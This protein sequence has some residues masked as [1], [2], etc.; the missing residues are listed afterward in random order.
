MTDLIYILNDDRYLPKR[1][2]RGTPL[3]PHGLKFKVTDYEFLFLSFA[4]K[5]LRPRCNQTS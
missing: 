4:F 5:L 3:S 2:G 1:L